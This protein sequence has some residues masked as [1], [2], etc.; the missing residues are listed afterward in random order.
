MKKIIVFNLFLCVIFVLFGI[1]INASQNYTDNEQFFDITEQVINKIKITRINSAKESK[2]KTKSYEL[3]YLEIANRYEL[4]TWQIKDRDEITIYE[5][6]L[7]GEYS[8]EQSD[9]MMIK[10]VANPGEYDD[11]EGYLTIR[12]VIS[13]DG[14]N[15][16][17]DKS[18]IVT[19]TVKYAGNYDDSS[20]TPTFGIRGEDRLVIGHGSGAYYNSERSSI[21]DGHYQFYSKKPADLRA[22]VTTWSVTQGFLRYTD[23]LDTK[24]NLANKLNVNNH[25]HGDKECMAIYPISLTSNTSLNAVYIHNER[26]FGGKLSISAGAYGFSLSIS[27]AHTD[28]SM[29]P[30]SLSA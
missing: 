10:S 17:G 16:F 19:V 28:Y 23:F 12:T 7:D 2:G 11:P 3:E 13:S 21:V 22:Y 25:F 24:V 20:Q 30:I 27:G 4:N 5:E 8:P 29:T 14:Y 18:Y 9:E 26:L 6:L 1:N 15:S